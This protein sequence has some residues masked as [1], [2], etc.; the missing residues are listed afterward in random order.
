MPKTVCM[1]RI[2]TETEFLSKS[3]DLEESLIQGKLKEFCDRKIAESTSASDKSIWSF[4]K[5]RVCVRT[6][7]WHACVCGVLVCVCVRACACVC[8]RARA[9]S[10][11]FTPLSIHL[12]P[13]PSLPQNYIPSR[14]KLR[15]ILGNAQH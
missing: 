12:S 14:K 1:S 4:M 2:V 3:Q 11:V 13:T 5:V 15:Y 8:M 6:N 10:W 7:V 9:I